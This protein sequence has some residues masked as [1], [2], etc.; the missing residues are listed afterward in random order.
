MSK[1][2]AKAR[3]DVMKALDAHR[4][5]VMEKTFDFTEKQPR[6]KKT[7]KAK[8]TAEAIDETAIFQDAVAMLHITPTAHAPMFGVARQTLA[9]WMR[10]ETKPKPKAFVILTREL[11]RAARSLDEIEKHMAEQ[12]ERLAAAMAKAEAIRA[13]LAK[14]KKDGRG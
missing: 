14:I 11:V 5:D 10:G 13:D 8:Q 9:K 1:T 12:D 4:A 7:A 6:A 3:L 2:E